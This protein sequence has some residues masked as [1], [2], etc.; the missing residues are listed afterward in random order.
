MHQD[1]YTYL[2]MT[3]WSHT[4][5]AWNTSL[6]SQETFQLFIKLFWVALSIFVSLSN[7]L[8]LQ[9]SCYLTIPLYV[10]QLPS[11]K[12]AW[13]GQEFYDRFREHVVERHLYL[14][15]LIRF[16]VMEHVWLRHR[17][18]KN[19]FGFRI[20]VWLTWWPT[21]LSHGLHSSFSLCSPLWKVEIV[22]C[23]YA[24][25]SQFKSNIL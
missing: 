20:W 4:L 9:I 15:S 11:S 22:G 16:W 13:R 2:T 5:R 12:N 3:S 7:L 17:R 14:R 6:S 10:P 19:P 21:S 18:R 24:S 25:N 1:R 23:I 8:M